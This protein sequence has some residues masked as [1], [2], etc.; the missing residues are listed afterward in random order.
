M[1]RGP[2]RSSRRAKDLRP[3]FVVDFIGMELDE[4]YLDVAGA[5]TKALVAPC[6]QEKTRHPLTRRR[7]PATLN[8]QLS[9]PN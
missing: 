7:V 1:R 5:R 4:H 9:L 8:F 6:S 2:E 3:F